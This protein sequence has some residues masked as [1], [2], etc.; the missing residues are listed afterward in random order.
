MTARLLREIAFGGV[1]RP[2][3]SHHGDGGGYDEDAKDAEYSIHAFLAKRN[4]FRTYSL[5]DGLE[6]EAGWIGF[7]NTTAHGP[8]T[9]VTYPSRIPTAL[10]M[11][12]RQPCQ[13]ALLVVC[14]DESLSVLGEGE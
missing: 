11:I 10:L 8:I 3:F 7:T 14:G 5:R 13:D 12:V 9:L 2:V 6:R 4:S 1:E